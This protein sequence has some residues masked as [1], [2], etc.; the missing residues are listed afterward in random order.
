MFVVSSNTSVEE[1]TNS[2]KPVINNFVPVVSQQ[3]EDRGKNWSTEKK[4]KQHTEL[5]KYN[6]CA[7]AFKLL[8]QNHTI[9]VTKK[10]L[11]PGMPKDLK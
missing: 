10:N 11:I 7:L 6:I 3:N 5:M 4:E 1:K 8:G 9:L 2:G